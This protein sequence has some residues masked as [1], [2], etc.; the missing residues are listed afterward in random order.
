MCCLT[1]QTENDLKVNVDVAHDGKNINNV[2]KHKF[3]CGQ[4]SLK[5]KQHSFLKTNFT[6]IEGNKCVFEVF[7]A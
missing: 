4:S 1:L 6:T 5:I 3:R 2:L 7:M